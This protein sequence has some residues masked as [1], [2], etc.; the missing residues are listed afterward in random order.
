MQLNIGEFGYF[1]IEIK[2]KIKGKVYINDISG[3]FEVADVDSR[4]VLLTDGQSEL[5]ISKSQ[6][7][8]FEPK[9]R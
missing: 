7:T 6:I 3:H 8:K 4:N 5:L 9:Q 1:E 2:K